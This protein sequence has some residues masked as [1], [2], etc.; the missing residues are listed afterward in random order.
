M[1]LAILFGELWTPTCKVYD[2]L[3]LLL[4][5]EADMRRGHRIFLLGIRRVLVQIFLEYV[6]GWRLC[7]QRLGNI[8]IVKNAAADLPTCL[9]SQIR[10]PSVPGAFQLAISSTMQ[11][12]SQQRFL[13]KPQEL[14]SSS[15]G[16]PRTNYTCHAR[17]QIQSPHIVFH[18]E[19]RPSKPSANLTVSVPRSRTAVRCSSGTAEVSASRPLR[20]IQHKDEAFWFYRF[21]S[22]VYDHVG[23]LRLQVPIYR[24]LPSVYNADMY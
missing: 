5:Q 21:L 23:A 14:I 19:P 8:H 13:Q 7:L 9:D 2:S 12:I 16:P 10:F 24:H 3:L 22:I 17:M 4:V 20:L 15:R 18:R 1:M 11:S 6:L